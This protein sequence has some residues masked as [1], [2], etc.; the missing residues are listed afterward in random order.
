MKPLDQWSEQELLADM[1]QA[2]P[3]TEQQIRWAGSE[4]VER[5]EDADLLALCPDEYLG[6]IYALV[7]A[8]RGVRL[9]LS[10]AVEKIAEMD[11]ARLTLER[12]C[13]RLRLEWS[14]SRGLKENG[15]SL[16]QESPASPPESK[17]SRAANE[18]N[19]SR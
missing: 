5:I 7:A 3:V 11:A 13:E 17:R 16:G 6:H 2:F 18:S 8:L 9:T 4:P 14:V 12:S 10:V 19:D 1:A 15:R